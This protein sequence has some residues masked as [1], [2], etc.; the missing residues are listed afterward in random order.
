[1]QKDYALL[2]HKEE[3]VL[4]LDTDLQPGS[5]IVVIRGRSCSKFQDLENYL[6]LVNE[7]NVA[8]LQDAGSQPMAN[9]PAG[10]DEPS[11]LIR[12][13][14]RTLYALLATLTRSSHRCYTESVLQQVSG[15]LPYSSPLDHSS[16]TM[17]NL[18]AM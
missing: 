14:I 6:T 10:T 11:V 12:T 8:L 9:V 15:P 18:F 17:R 3:V 5:F 2:V 7:Q 4:E 16:A 13:L 1:M